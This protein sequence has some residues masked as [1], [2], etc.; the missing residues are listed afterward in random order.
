MDE[1]YTVAN[2]IRVYYVTEGEGPLVLMCHGFPE[3]HYSWRH[4]MTPLAAAG[5]RAVA[6]DMPGFGRSDKPDVDYDVVWLSACIRGVIEGLGHSRAVVVG[7]DWGGV[8]VWSFARF[9][10]EV[11]AGVIAL[12][13]PDL[14]RTPVPPIDVL[15]AMDSPR[16]AYILAFQERGEAEAAFEADPRSF[17]ELFFL[18][19]ASYNKDVFPP[20]VIDVYEASFAPKGSI[21]PPLEY[22]RNM[23]RNWVLTAEHEGVSI[24]APALMITAE[25]DPVLAPALAEGME[26]RVPN[27]TTVMIERCG[28]WTQQEKPKETTAAMLDFLNSLKRLTPWD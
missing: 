18:G 16:G 17:L 27:L 15:R 5:F 12:N 9:H 26:K 3:S 11:V 7:H 4:Q 19:P 1:G 20:E 10:P 21:T 6:I 28:H 24:H 8:V 2:G 23:D 22:Y 14:R 13:T 25:N